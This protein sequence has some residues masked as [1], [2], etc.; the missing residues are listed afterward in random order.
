VAADP[1]AT[2]ADQDGHRPLDPL[3]P[4]ALAL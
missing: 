4:R 3:S 2:S 1:D